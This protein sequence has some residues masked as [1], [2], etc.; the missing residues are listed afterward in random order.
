M[1]RINASQ[2]EVYLSKGICM[3]K[4]AVRNSETCNPLP[5]VS[6]PPHPC[7]PARD[8][9]LQACEAMQHL[10]YLLIYENPPREGDMSYEAPVQ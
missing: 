5:K 1:V 10:A 8:P 3:Q 6:G 4:R 7:A 2:P 9:I